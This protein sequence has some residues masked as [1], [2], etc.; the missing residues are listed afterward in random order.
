MKTSAYIMLAGVLLFTLACNQ[1]QKKTKVES[2]A[3][4]TAQEMKAG[5]DV[6]ACQH[7]SKIFWNGSKPGGEHTGF[8]KIKKGNYIVEDDKLVG[9]EFVI[10]MTSIVN[11]DIEDEAMNAKLV[12][13]LN[14]ADFFHVDSFPEG[15]FVITNVKE[16][17]DEDFSH[18][19]SGDLT[20]K[21]VTHPI[22]F[23]ATVKVGD[24]KVS[25]SSEEFILNR[26]LWNVNYG[27][28]S[29]FKELKDKFINDEFGL[30][31]EAHSM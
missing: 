25:A 26:T 27:S 16:I 17:K 8:I 14:S 23:K 24:G 30:Q 19:I 7:S 21:S 28:K 10:D 5:D 31:I 18:E 12:G 3:E 20:L 2:T 13:H 15:Q 6:M 9:G 29:I 1:T 4:G 22:V 11:I